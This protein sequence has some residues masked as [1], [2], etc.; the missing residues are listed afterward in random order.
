[1]GA[2][3]AATHLAPVQDLMSIQEG[4][5]LLAVTGWPV[6]YKQLAHD[7]A[8]A[9]ARSERHGRTNYYSASDMVEV[10]RDRVERLAGTR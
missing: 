2:P 7:L 8:A 4:V 10:H 6:T 5:D 1:M 9:G 3:V